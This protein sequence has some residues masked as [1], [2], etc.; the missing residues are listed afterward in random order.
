MPIRTSN[1][2]SHSNGR[3]GEDARRDT[4]ARGDGG[5]DDGAGEQDVRENDQTRQGCAKSAA[6]T[7][8]AGRRVR[9][10]RGGGGAVPRK[11][12]GGVGAATGTTENDGKGRE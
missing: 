4:R 11:G 10:T 5:T 12:P 6:G 2:H 3:A 7:L 9:R 8:P 1:N